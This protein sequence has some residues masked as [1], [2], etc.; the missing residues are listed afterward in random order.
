MN[1]W[2]QL[3][4]PFFVLA[5]MDDVTDVVFRQ[6]VADVAAPEVFFTEFVSVSGLTSEAGREATMLRL[7]QSA[8][9][10]RP[11]VAQIWGNCPEQ[12]A[13]AASMIQPLGFAGIDINMGCP[14][15]D[16][17]KSG[18]GG[19]LIGD[20]VRSAEIIAATKAGAGDLPISIKTRLGRHQIITE[21]WVGW[22]LNQRL[23]A[24][25]IHGRT[26]KE[27]SKVE[28]HWDEIKRVVQLRNQ[29]APHTVIIGNGDIANRETGLQ[30]ALATGVDGIMIGRGIFQSIDAFSTNPPLSVSPQRQINLLAHHLDLYEQWGS[31]KSF[32]TLKKFF[33]VY[34]HSWPQAHELRKRLMDS[35]N[36]QQVREIIKLYTADSA[37]LPPPAK[38][39]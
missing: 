1:F 18:S 20:T 24:I 3:T 22:L 30:Q 33:K 6:A 28:A 38:L 34:I 21:E 14:A 26:V 23:A 31:T 13:Q 10:S 25:T 17:V 11:L 9:S 15:K 4:K 39:S 32:Q 35:Q 27:M 2:Q 29:L 16:V 36:T 12:F 8:S 19:G 5:P 7:R 37:I